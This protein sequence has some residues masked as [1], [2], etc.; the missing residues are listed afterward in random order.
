MPQHLIFEG[1][2]LSGKSRI[3][4][5]IYNF[6]EPKYNRRKVIMDGCHWFNCDL[7]FFGTEHGKP[8]IE[9]YLGIFKELREKNLIVEKLHLSDRIYNSI[10]RDR[11]IDYTDVENKLTELDFR[12]ILTTF[13]EDEILLQ[14]RINDRLNI[15][16]H[17]ASILKP[18]RWYI[19]QQKRYI[20]EVEK[21]VLPHLIVETRALPDKGV[22][23]NILHWIGEE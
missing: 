22:I 2:E 5:D 4:S 17:Y 13:P 9:G 20:E 8:V 16:P 7:G 18:V 12:L 14:E 21:S 15:Y 3:I 11:D 23:D 6:L 19:E 1:A 10:Y